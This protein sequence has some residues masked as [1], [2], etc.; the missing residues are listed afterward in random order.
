VLLDDQPE[1]HQGHELLQEDGRVVPPGGAGAALTFA[2]IGLYHPGLFAG[3]NP[4]IPAPLAPL[5]RAAM[6][7]R[8]VTGE[9][10]AGQWADIGTP[11]RLAQLDRMLR[12]QPDPG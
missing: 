11:Q 10:H 6:T 4:G 1:Q 2:G 3:I 7:D 9:H 8:L 12:N 5:L